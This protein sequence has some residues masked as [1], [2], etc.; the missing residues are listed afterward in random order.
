MAEDNVR[1]AAHELG[2]RRELL[3]VL[4]GGVCGAAVL[5]LL[6]VPA[7]GII[8][9]VLGSAAVSVRHERPRAQPAL[10]AIGLV[11]LGTAAGLRLD[12]HTLE[13]LAEVALPLLGAIAALL[14]LNLVLAVVLH[15]RFGLDPV[16][17]L[18]AAAP[19]GVSE[20]AAM[21]DEMNARLAMV[22]AIHVVRVVAVVLVALPILVHVLGT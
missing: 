4:T 18:L 13:V 1:T 2:P 14:A 19:G 3:M 11:L 5:T 15:R 9:A 17:A 10:R 21:A 8:G 6:G 22:V 7:G 12:R 20:I 16:S